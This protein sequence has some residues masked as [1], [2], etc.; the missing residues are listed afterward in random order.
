MKNS[1]C[2]C[3]KAD[4]TKPF[5]I[6]DGHQLLSCKRCSLVFLA[7]SNAD[8]RDFIDESKKQKI[9]YWSF[10]EYY[11]KYQKVFDQYFQQRLERL[12]LYKLP[13]GRF[14]DIGIGYGFWAKYLE[15]AGYNTL[16]IDFSEEVVE[17]AKSQLNLE[18]QHLDF[19]S[20]ETDEKFSAIFM[21]DVLEHFKEPDQMLLKAKSML[22]NGG[23]IY[24]QVPNVLGFRIPYG[25][26]LG[27]PYHIWQFSPKSLKRLLAKSGLAHNAI[28][29]TGIQGVI[30]VHERGGP[31]LLTSLRWSLA[32]LFKIGNRV[33]I[34]GQ[35][36]EGP[37][38]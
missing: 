37:T 12:K 11:K 22:M 3:K 2:I 18:A 34:I 8:L 15:N 30:G 28:Y 16:G 21:F 13:K 27:L 38:Q 32:N 26:G 19:E 6:V 7:E 35:K 10:P 5:K 1:C 29:W 17:Y 33:Q 14:L 4:Q 31:S 20:F 9:E 25:H 24:I 36:W 23:V